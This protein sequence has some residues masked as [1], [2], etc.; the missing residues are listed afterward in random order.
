MAA[1]SFSSVS[2]YIERVRFNRIVIDSSLTAMWYWMTLNSVMTVTCCLLQC[3]GPG[4]TYRA[5]RPVFQLHRHNHWEGFASEHVGKVL[6]NHSNGYKPANSQTYTCTCTSRQMKFKHVRVLFIYVR[7]TLICSQM[8]TA[9][10][11][12][13]A[14]TC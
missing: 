4:C 1:F 2:D 6:L 10:T 11:C 5:V 14:F 8:A 12:T 7:G 3:N 9:S 13:V